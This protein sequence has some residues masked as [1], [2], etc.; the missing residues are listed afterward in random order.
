MTRI[1]PLCGTTFLKRFGADHVTRWLQLFVS[2]IP[3]HQVTSAA[4]NPTLPIEGSMKGPVDVNEV[5]Q[6]QDRP[7]QDETGMADGRT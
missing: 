7:I 2:C 3:C 1:E 6:R 4:A 5:C